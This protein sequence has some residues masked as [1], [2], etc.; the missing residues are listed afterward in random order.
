MKWNAVIILIMN[1]CSFFT[2][3]QTS[4]SQVRYPWLYKHWNNKNL[5]CHTKLKE[6]ST[7]GLS[8]SYNA[9]TREQEGDEK[10]NTSAPLEPSKV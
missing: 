7:I 1:T 9:T 5:R 6:Q 10:G 4:H 3:A 2:N 8:L